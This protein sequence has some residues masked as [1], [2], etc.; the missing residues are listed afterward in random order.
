VFFI[1]FGIHSYST[2]T[3]PKLLILIFLKLPSSEMISIDPSL[4]GAGSGV[5]IVSGLG[6]MKTISVIP[7]GSEKLNIASNFS[8]TGGFRSSGLG[9]KADGV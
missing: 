9:E 1:Y 4:L 6:G 5:M 2:V 3:W 7:M 8:T